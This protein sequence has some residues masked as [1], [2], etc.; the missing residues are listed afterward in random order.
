[1]R[2][3]AD[4]LADAASVTRCAGID[5]FGVGRGKVFPSLAAVIPSEQLVLADLQLLGQCRVDPWTRRRSCCA[6]AAGWLTRPRARGVVRH[7]NPGV[8]L[9]YAWSR[10]RDQ[11][12]DPGAGLQTSSPTPT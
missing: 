2:R 8:P 1:M 6:G 7:D 5:E 4:R 12:I 9:E 11:I 3:L 10:E